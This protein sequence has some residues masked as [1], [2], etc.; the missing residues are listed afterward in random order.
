MVQ[1]G[2]VGASDMSA[3][4]IGSLDANAAVVGR[5]S[6]LYESMVKVGDDNRRFYDDQSSLSA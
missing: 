5:A 2:Q 1:I 6:V 4:S 3:M